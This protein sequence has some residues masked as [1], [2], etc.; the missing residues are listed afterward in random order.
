MMSPEIQNAAKE[1]NLAAELSSSYDKMI[2]VKVEMIKNQIVI[3][4]H[5]GEKVYSIGM[6]FAITNN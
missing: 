1:V 3:Y 6:G 2:K 5:A 4:P